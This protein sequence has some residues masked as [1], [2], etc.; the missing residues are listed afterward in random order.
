MVGQNYSLPT[1]IKKETSN[2]E[3]KLIV[4]MGI[5]ASGKSTYAEKL[6]EEGKIVLSS[7]ELRL[8]LY[9]DVDH[10]DN[11]GHIFNTLF[12]RAREQLKLGNDVVI[13]AT[14]INSKKRIHLIQQEFKHHDNKEAYA[15]MTPYHNCIQ[16]NNMRDRVIPT[17]A[18]KRMYMN[19]Q[20]PTFEEGWS[21]IK[22][23]MCRSTKDVEYFS[24]FRANLEKLITD[25]NQSHKKLIGALADVIYPF[26]NIYD[27]P[28][29]SKYHAF[30][31]S[32]HTYYV[33]HYLIN[34][35][36]VQA[37]G[38]D[39]RLAVLWT[40]LFHDTG[41]FETKTFEGRNRETSRYAHFYGHEN[42]SS[43]HALHYLH[44]MG[45]SK[46]FTL[47]VAKYCLWH[48]KLLNM[49]ADWGSKSA[50]KFMNFVGEDTY[51]F[52][53]LFREADTNAK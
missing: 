50:K 6:K 44:L 29:D 5:P 22:F 32:R 37:M 47:K 24:T 26:S 36:D 13:D 10:Q 35:A 18:I 33:W 41:K 40:A 27:L 52:L 4:L 51:N 3:N 38:E 16:H 14:N 48:M 25:P 34:H 19:L 21:D 9:G 49:D 20:I 2:M 1:G 45:Y 23:I 30:S 7:D 53:T 39:D 28:Q 8:E 43:Q 31:V 46:E 15:F 17:H 11:N 12:T 42:V